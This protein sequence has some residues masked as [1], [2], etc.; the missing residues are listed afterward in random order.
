MFP[1]IIT[2][3]NLLNFGAVAALTTCFVIKLPAAKAARQRLLLAQ[4]DQEEA[5]ARTYRRLA[6]P[7]RLLARLAFGCYI[8]GMAL[9]ML[10]GG[11]YNI[12]NV[13][14][15][16]GVTVAAVLVAEVAEVNGFS[17]VPSRPRFKQISV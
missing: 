13:A 7:Q 4:G 5:A 9:A 3:L 8:F 12:L 16:M 2:L 14:L 10:V 6:R 17:V 11:H 15:M 1:S